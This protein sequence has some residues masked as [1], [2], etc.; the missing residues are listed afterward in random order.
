MYT[1]EA[2]ASAERAKQDAK[3]KLPIK[4]RKWYDDWIESIYQADIDQW[5]KQITDMIGKHLIHATGKQNTLALVAAFRDVNE[6]IF[7]IPRDEFINTAEKIVSREIASWIEDLPHEE[8]GYY[9]QL[10]TPQ[11]EAFR[12][13]RA[14][15]LRQLMK[16]GN[17]TFFLGANELGTRISVDDRRA[18]N[19]LKGFPFLKMIEKGKPWQ[20]GQRAKATSW[21]WI[22]PLGHDPVDG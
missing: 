14:L 6:S 7:S 3:S 18:A 1:W 5:Q 2:L 11:Q 22:Y 9:K 20:S 15:A 17:S 10:P 13:C 12:I 4:I 16:S 8:A 19:I 21:Q